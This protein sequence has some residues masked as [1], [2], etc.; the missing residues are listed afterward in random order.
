[1]TEKIGPTQIEREELTPD[2]RYYVE[3]SETVSPRVED[4]V[5]YLDAQDKAEKK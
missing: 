2:Q 3:L 5:D 1:M 4:I